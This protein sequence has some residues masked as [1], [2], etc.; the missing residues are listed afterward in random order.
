MATGVHGP[1]CVERE[2][3]LRHWTLHLYTYTARLL[4]NGEEYMIRPGCATVNPP[5]VETVYHFEQKSRHLCAH[6]DPRLF[7]R[8][9]R[10]ELGD[11]PMHIRQKL[12]HKP[13]E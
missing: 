10:R 6:F 4:I 1:H 12:R 7:N 5:Y 13:P 8:I 3:S 2:L 11:S 9:I